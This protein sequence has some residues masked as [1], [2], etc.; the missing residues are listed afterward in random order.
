M[1]VVVVVVVVCAEIYT[2]L[3]LERLKKDVYR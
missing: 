2:V 3:Y 1:V